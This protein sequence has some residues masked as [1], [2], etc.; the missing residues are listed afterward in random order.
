MSRSKLELKTRLY[1]IAV[2]LCMAVLLIWGVFYLQTANELIR[3]RKNYISQVS[4]GIIDTLE[5]TFLSLE[6]TAVALS[7]SEDVKTFLK[8]TD[9]V[10]FHE[11]S[12][13]VNKYLDSIYQPNGLVQDILIY[14]M[15]GSFHRFRGDLGNT[16]AVR[17]HY[18]VIPEKLPQQIAV[19]LNDAAYIGYITGVYE[20]E[21]LLGYAVFLMQDSRLHQLFEQYTASDTLHIGLAVD[22][23]MAAA[24][25]DGLLG[26]SLSKLKEN[27]RF[28]SV[29]QIGLTPFQIV[30][31]DKSETLRQSQ[32]T[33]AAVAIL[34]TIVLLAMMLF[35][36][37]TLHKL[38]FR[39]ALSI[40]E[41]ARNISSGDRQTRLE[42]TGVEEFDR[43]VAQV[44]AMIAGLED[45][46]RTLYQMQLDIQNA[47]IDRQRA[48][49]ISLKKQINAHFT[50][51]TLNVIKRL[52]EIGQHEKVR[53]MCDGLANLLRYANDAEETIGGM[54]E[55]TVL[56]KYVDIMQIRYPD[57]FE[58]IFEV[59]DQIDEVRLPRMLVQP[60][61]ENA[62]QH[63]L[64]PAGYGGRLIISAAIKD[65]QVII[66]ISDNGC[67][68]QPDELE[69]LRD[70]IRTAPQHSNGDEGLTQI[71][72]PNIQKRVV[73]AFGEGYG[74]EIESK[75]GYGTIVTLTLPTETCTEKEF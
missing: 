28:L 47:Q 44:N 64:C 38:F 56:Q 72:L 75:C 49:I 6:H 2:L 13:A 48:I 3:T 29:R 59:D 10:R 27:T 15:N 51:N 40:I 21:Q 69:A 34:T 31:A 36:F 68:M 7:A 12:E 14:N 4:D 74:L 42:F 66:R 18:L 8:E 35:F 54:E 20:D 11:K 16:A 19:S 57:R 63:G 23:K 33:F 39:P 32:Q 30:V 70:I 26:E 22:G 9:P 67:G 55:M 71:A 65:R 45:K 62:I 73:S 41:N 50:V 25:N 1:L 58:V 60:L 24:S 52:D 53:E 5:T 17:I 43:L 46:N 37:R 61:V